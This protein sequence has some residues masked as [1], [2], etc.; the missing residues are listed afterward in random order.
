MWHVLSTADWKW[1][2]GVDAAKA[3]YGKVREAISPLR[4]LTP[5]GG[6]YQVSWLCLI[7]FGA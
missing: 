2:A 3:A 5:G 1:D 6:A 7:V 4:T